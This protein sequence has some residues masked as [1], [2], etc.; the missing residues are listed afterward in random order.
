MRGKNVEIDIDFN[1]LGQILVR[2]ERILQ[3]TKKNVK[4]FL[5]QEKL[6]E[7]KLLQGENC[8]LL[9]DNLWKKGYEC[10]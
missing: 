5:D 3:N 8:L 4:I 6:K 1:L 10:L 2:G 7:F 9:L